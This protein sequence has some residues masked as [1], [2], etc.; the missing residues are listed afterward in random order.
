MKSEGLHSTYS[1][2]ALE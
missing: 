1:A 2:T